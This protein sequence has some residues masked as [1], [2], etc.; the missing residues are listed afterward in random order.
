MNKMQ[1]PHSADRIP[2]P[3]LMQML[4]YDYA[5][6]VKL[7]DNMVDLAKKKATA[8]TNYNKAFAKRLLE[9]RNDK[10]PVSIIKDVAR[11][12]PDISKLQYEM[13]VAD[14]VFSACRESIKDVREH[15]G[16][17]RSLLTWQRSEAQAG[18]SA[19][20]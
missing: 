5:H 20:F 9:K 11:G 14:A 16:I 1:S 8:E 17:L 6:L 12:D 10:V 15:I 19:P 4:D 18:H 7:N 2:A 3:Q 13:I